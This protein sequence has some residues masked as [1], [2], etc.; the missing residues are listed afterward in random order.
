MTTVVPKPSP[1]NL[2]SD[3]QEKVSLPEPEALGVAVR[4]RDPM[5]SGPTP[6][7]T[8]EGKDLGVGVTCPRSGQREERISP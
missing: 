4:V 8:P 3:F 1:L 2:N 7:E 5:A 6:L